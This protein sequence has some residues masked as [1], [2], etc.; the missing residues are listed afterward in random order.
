MLIFKLTYMNIILFK[1]WSVFD[2]HDSSCQFR[3]YL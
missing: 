3:S 1:N 2:F